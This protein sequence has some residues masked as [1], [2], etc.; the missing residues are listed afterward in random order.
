[1]MIKYLNKI[2]LLPILIL[3][4]GSLPNVALVQ[5]QAEARSL[6]QGFLDGE[7]APLWNLM[8]EPMQEKAG[9]LLVLT[10]LRAQLATQFGKEHAV[11]SERD[12]RYMDQNVYMRT[13]A[14]SATEHP[15]QVIVVLTDQG[16]VSGFK[17]TKLDVPAESPHLDYQTKAD[18]RL[19][20]DGAWYVYWGGR[21][22]AHNYHANHPVQ[23]FALDLAILRDGQ[24]YAGDPLQVENYHCWEAP[25]LSP[26]TA[27]VIKVVDGLPDQTI[28]ASDKEN[29]A[30]NHV[31]LDLGN[32]EYAVLAH[33]REG[34][35]RVAEGDAVS[36][37]QEL[38]L[39]GNS[40]N[41]SE[42]HLH[43][44]LQ[45]EPVFNT[46]LGLP[47]QFQNYS[48]NGDP[49]DRGEPVMTEVVEPNK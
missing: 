37:G 38:G 22:M 27:T 20:F 39:C 42:P 46:G 49:V 17:V 3:G 47:A 48:A 1:M 2:R 16:A 41:S 14:W 25:I 32:S 10:V 45:T 6:V 15:I 30:G 33:F 28:G 12:F 13:S 40:G 29:P 8:N 35:I 7:V 26:A 5:S 43:F 36:Q 24:S 18:L 44:H 4:L 34:S 21:D 23:R 11:L 9:S 19:P 31:I